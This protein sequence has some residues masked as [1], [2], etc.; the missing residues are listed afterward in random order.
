VGDIQIVL[1]L[2]A[3]M[4]SGEAWALYAVFRGRPEPAGLIVGVMAG[5]LAGLVLRAV[6]LP[7]DGG[8]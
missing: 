6:T 5:A 2:V 7:V 4:T 3:I 1:T 8:T